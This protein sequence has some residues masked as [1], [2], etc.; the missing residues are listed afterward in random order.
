M[1]QCAGIKRDGTRCR[2][3]AEGPNGFC[4]AH[5][6]K[7]AAARSRLAAHAGRGGT[8]ETAE[9]KHRL[10]QL[11]DDVL[12]GKAETGP[13]AVA[14]QCLN[15]VLRAIELERRMKETEELERRLEALE[16][17]EGA[18]PDEGYID[19]RRR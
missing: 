6:P 8:R 18:T 7:N 5:D 4:W 16:A 3:S 14:N 2:R 19:W 15:T 10:R 12:A 11:V 13:A 9:I 17:A 1:S